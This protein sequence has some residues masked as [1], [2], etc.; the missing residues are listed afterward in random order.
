MTALF[1]FSLL[2][3]LYIYIGYPILV[4][5]LARAFG[6]EPIRRSITPSVSLLIPAYNEEAHIEAK[7]RNSLSLDYP[8]DKL[9]IVVASDGSTDR[10]N[11]IVNPF[12]REGVKLIMMRDNIG[13]SAMLDRTVPLLRGEIIVFSD[14]IGRAH[15]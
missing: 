4:F 9:D 15:V 10:T 13:K 8:K 14:E 2:I 7:L 3:L 6:R 5:A 12:R 11:A 1:W